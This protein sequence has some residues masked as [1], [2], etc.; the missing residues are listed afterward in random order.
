MTTVLIA[1]DHPVYREGLRRVMESSLT[2][3]ITHEASNGQE[4]LRCIQQSAPDVAVLDVSMPLLSGLEV[5]RQVKA[6]H[7]TTRIIFVTMYQQEDLFNEAMDVGA[8][9][10]V[11]K[12]SAMSD[13]VAGITAVAQGQY[14]LSPAI[15]GFLVNRQAGKS[16]F[17]T[18]HRGI[19]LL[20]PSER[21]ILRLIAENRT[22]KEV[23][24]ELGVSVRTV[25]NHRANICAKLELRGIHS[26]VRFA[27][28][29]R[30]HL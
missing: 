23:A 22:S 27:F 20:T 13:I 29:N 30:T 14:Y 26:L 25:E 7:S 6:S 5:A 8:L 2:I 28:E 4:A 21:R 3:R 18:K 11:L 17:E 10:Y 9:G 16:A 24:N 1:D 19:A 15:S 12:E